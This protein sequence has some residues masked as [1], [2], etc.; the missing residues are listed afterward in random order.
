M[1]QVR[2]RLCLVRLLVGCAA[3]STVLAGA[4]QACQESSVR[5][6]AQA[7]VHNQSVDD[8]ETIYLRGKR[9]AERSDFSRAAKAFQE[10]AAAGHAG[11]MAQLGA[12]YAGGQG[13]SK[14][15]ARAVELFQR[16]VDAGS[17]EG[18]SHLG[19]AYLAGDGVERDALRAREVF[20]RGAALGDA[21]CM[22]NLGI[23]Y[24]RG[25]GV[26]PDEAKGLEW[27]QR[28]ASAGSDI[29]RTYLKRQVI[30]DDDPSSP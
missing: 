24:L 7:A 22:H 16:S 5:S 8:P 6:D 14:D 17:P 3:T 15:P 4:L 19:V 9:Y 13:V 27:L 20:E 23:V 28:A 25:Y 1:P 21:T 10:A 30:E 2:D 29:A 11:A 18:M 26:E 12:L